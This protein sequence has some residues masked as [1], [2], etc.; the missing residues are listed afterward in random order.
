MT[1]RTL[2]SASTALLIL[3]ACGGEPEAPEETVAPE[4]KIVAEPEAPEAEDRLTAVKAEILLGTFESAVTDLT[5]WEMQ[6]FGFQS[7]IFAANGDAG[8]T[9]VRADGGEARTIDTSPAAR[10]LA[11]AQAD[12]GETLLVTLSVDGSVEARTIGDMGTDPRS[13]TTLGNPKGLCSDGE[14]VMAVSGVGAT[15][16]LGQTSLPVRD[17]PSDTLACA[18]VGD[19]FYFQSPNGWDRLT[20]D[21]LEPSPLDPD[22]S[23]LLGA[24]NEVF[25]VA[26]DGVSGTLTV[27]DQS[28][29]LQTEEGEP[30]RPLMVRPAYGNFGGVLRDGALIVLDE[31][32][33][34]YLVGWSS[35][36]NALGLPGSL[37]SLR[38]PVRSE[39]PAFSV[40]DEGLELDIKKPGFEEIKAPLPP[41]GEEDGL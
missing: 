37:S 27:N 1:P 12:G 38:A 20:I 17:V 30:L 36:A 25:A 41:T 5:A 33:R 8:I 24:G 23:T 39:E 10:F 16:L 11:T 4:P 21:G 6:P 15:V 31:Q 29:D 2:L 22:A 19:D 35:V 9:M 13:L 3:T 7:L 32:R 26:A 18:A 34:L 40:P 28:L 14:L